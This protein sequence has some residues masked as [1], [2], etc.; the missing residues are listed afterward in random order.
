MNQEQLGNIGG[1]ARVEQKSAEI[2]YQLA[3]FLIVRGAESR[4]DVLQFSFRSSGGLCGAR[5]KGCLGS[6]ETTASASG[7]PKVEFKKKTKNS[8]HETVGDGTFNGHATCTY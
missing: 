2:N 8:L 5:V 7:F 1:V 3:V 6:K 4:L